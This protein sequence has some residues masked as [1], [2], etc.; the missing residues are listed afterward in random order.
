MAHAYD[1]E[2]DWLD[3][4]NS[5]PSLP[6]DYGVADKLKLVCGG[7]VALDTLL[8]VLSPWKY[9][10]KSDLFLLDVIEIKDAWGW[11][12]DALEHKHD[13]DV[14][15]GD[16]QAHVSQYF[17]PVEEWGESP[18][19]FGW[20]LHVSRLYQV[21]DSI[22]E[23]AE[24]GLHLATGTQLDGE[25]LLSLKKL[26]DVIQDMTFVTQ[27]DDIAY[28]ARP[29]RLAPPVPHGSDGNACVSWSKTCWDYGDKAVNPY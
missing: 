15:I 10:D 6:A 14:L 18:D 25:N 23:C 1:D 8:K 16:L 28:M 24:F 27:P 26:L 13:L 5:N 11:L 7:S 9:G 29:L 19:Y 20:K 17:K 22:Y 12:E 21:F 4:L 2:P 3:I